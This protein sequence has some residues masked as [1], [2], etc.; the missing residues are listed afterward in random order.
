[1]CSAEIYL[2]LENR[3][4]VFIVFHAAIVEI[5]DQ[6]WTLTGILFDNEF[7]SDPAQLN[8]VL[9][10]CILN[11]QDFRFSAP[12]SIKLISRYMVLAIYE[13]VSCVCPVCVLCVC[14]QGFQKS[15]GA[16]FYLCA[17]GH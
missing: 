13:C 1:M 12:Y 2:R 10:Y 15:G 7:V 3:F 8:C 6:I 17:D 5:C 11:V 4:T 16:E 9:L 14:V